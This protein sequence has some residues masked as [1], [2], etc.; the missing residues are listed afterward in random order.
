MILRLVM[1]LSAALMFINPLA[2]QTEPSIFEKF[3]GTWTA[4]GN[5]FGEQA[6]S[7]MVWSQT[8]DSQFYRID[9]SILFDDSGTNGFIGIGHYKL[10]KE[11]K[12]EGYWAD[13]SG[14][15]HPLSAATE[16]DRILTLWGK[17]GSKM[18]RT[19]YHL[20]PDGKLQVTDWQLTSKGW[21]EFNKA[22][23]QKQPADQ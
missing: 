6:R 12:V 14:D 7:T 3:E 20:L 16:A 5:S 8:L 4:T 22:V 21:E 13:N 2:A 19:E 17:A 18:G 9:Y 23:F 1:T 11:P 15:L 10:S